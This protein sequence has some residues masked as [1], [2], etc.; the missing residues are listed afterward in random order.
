MSP[1]SPVSPPAYL[2]CIKPV[3]LPIELCR[4]SGPFHAGYISH[5]KSIAWLGVGLLAP[6][7]CLLPVDLPSFTAMPF[8]HHSKREGQLSSDFTW[9]NDYGEMDLLRI[10]SFQT[11]VVCRAWS[12]PHSSGL[13]S[14]PTHASHIL[15][16]ERGCLWFT[17]V[18]HQDQSLLCH[19]IK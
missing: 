7:S 14:S 3:N 16:R 4:H 13:F 19:K 12:Y 1:F 15:A 9:E 5:G 8:K 10:F 18:Q 2:K 11:Y 17:T 6:L